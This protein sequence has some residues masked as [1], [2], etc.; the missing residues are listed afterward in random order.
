MKA[1]RQFHAATSLVSHHEVV[2]GNSAT[3]GGLFT[4]EYLNQILESDRRVTKRD[5]SPSAVGRFSRNTPEVSC[6]LSVP[7]GEKLEHNDN[8]RQFHATTSLVLHLVHR[9]ARVYREFGHY[10]RDYLLLNIFN[11]LESDRRVINTRQPV[12]RFI[13][14]RRSVFAEYSRSDPKLGVHSDA[15]RREK[16]KNSR[17]VPTAISRFSPCNT[18]WRYLQLNRYC[19]TI[20]NILLNILIISKVH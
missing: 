15:F 6:A 7:H 8:L 16:Q 9:E 2:T 10:W 12:G 17:P 3:V 20:N 5:I 13:A 14:S 4:T 18:K 1:L 11:Y 19:K